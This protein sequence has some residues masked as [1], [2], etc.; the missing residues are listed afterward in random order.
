MTLQ[1][2][3]QHFIN[4]PSYLETGAPKLAKQFNTSLELINKAKQEVRSLLKKDIMKDLKQESL[5][6]KEFA[7]LIGIDMD[8][9]PDIDYP[10]EKGILEYDEDLVCPDYKGFKEAVDE[11]VEQRE[12]D[13]WE[14]KVKWV[15]TKEKSTL[16][17][18]KESGTDYKKEFEEFLSKYNPKEQLVEKPSFKNNSALFVYTSDK[19][20]GAET[21]ENALFENTWN[22]EEFT[23][24]MSLL[25]KE[26]IRL[27]EIYHFESIVIFD[28]GDALD[29]FNKQTTRGGH[30]LPQNMSNRES[31]STFINV[32]TDFFYTLSKYYQGNLSFI[33]TGDSNHGGD[34]EW[35]C[36]KSLEAILNLRFPNIQTYIGDKFVE[37]FEIGDHCFITCHGKDSEDLK[38]PLPPVLNEKVELYFKKYIDYHRIQSK[39]IHVIKGDSHVASCQYGDFFRYKNVLSMYGASKWVQTNFM[40]NTR[41][42]SMDILSNG[43]ITEHQLFL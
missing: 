29:G 7:L 12:D 19:H 2:L 30:Q 13:K 9:D 6:L 33:T 16:L 11:F 28:L 38:Y 8:V 31:Y 15:K 35:I 27:N 26:I 4:H 20:I 1:Q 42:V 32:H 24:R 3:V 23:K 34:Y 10:K 40:S 36:N 21:K 43:S 41:G 37:H 18:K 17:V 5:S 14:E 39:Y 22:K 25:A